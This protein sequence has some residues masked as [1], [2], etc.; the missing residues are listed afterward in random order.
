MAMRAKADADMA[1]AYAYTVFVKRRKAHDL[2][3]IVYVGYVEFGSSL[4]GAI[5]Q[6]LRY[7]FPGDYLETRRGYALS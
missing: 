6:A 1:L 7:A 4:V 3:H 5:A 2:T